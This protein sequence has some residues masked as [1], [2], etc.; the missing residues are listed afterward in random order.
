MKKIFLF[1]FVSIV[2]SNVKYD[3]KIKFFGIRVANCNVTYSD[4]IL[5]NKDLKKIE[6]RVLTNNFIN[7]FFKIDNNYIVVLDENYNTIYFKK[8]TLQPNLKNQIETEY[9]DG[10]LSYKNSN[11]LIDE[12]SINIF[13]VL[14]MIYNQDFEALNKV[15]GI[16]REGKYYNFS[17]K[18]K[19]DKIDI[20]IHEIDEN[21]HG[22]IEHTD[23]FS[24]GLF[25]DKTKKTII[26]NH[27]KKYIEKCIFKKGITTITASIERN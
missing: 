19:R 27:D 3:Y 23:I 8:D 17:S 13:T 11:I 9:V 18:I 20:F 6:Y 2:F 22:L 1:I 26:Y 15:T 21:N 12:N 5:Y 16:E 4:T 25:L 7:S 14:Y 24:W 10:S